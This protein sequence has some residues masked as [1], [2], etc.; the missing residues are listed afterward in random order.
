MEFEKKFKNKIQKKI[1]EQI[2]KDFQ[3]D[4]DYFNQVR[5]D[6]IEDTINEILR[7][8]KSIFSLYNKTVSDKSKQI[9]FDDKDITVDSLMELKR[10]IELTQNEKEYIEYENESDHFKNK[11]IEVII[12]VLVR[13]ILLEKIDIP[14]L[15]VVEQAIEELYKGNA[16]AKK[17]LHMKSLISG[18]LFEESEDKFSKM[19]S[20]RVEENFNFYIN[21]GGYALEVDTCIFPAEN[22]GNNFERSVSSILELFPF[23]RL[24]G[25]T[26]LQEDEYLVLFRA[27]K[28]GHHFIK[29]VDDGTFVEK[30]GG[31]APKKFVKWSESFENS[32]EAAFA[33]KKDHDIEYFD[34]YGSIIIPIETVK[35]FEETVIHTIQ[36]MQNTFEYHN[37]TF[38]LKKSDEG[39][40]YVCSMGKIVA[41]VLID[42]KDYDI[43]IKKEYK[44]YISNAKPTEI[45]IENNTQRTEK[46]DIEGGLHD[47]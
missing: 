42:D 29:Q 24:L 6:I 14:D 43:E 13:R 10:K 25:D 45:M 38:Q 21:C 12:E 47:R 26:K 37:H 33:V 3:G 4:W 2:E 7:E 9:Y 19:V 36:N 44:E 11:N 23:V 16:Y 27:S 15:T 8:I 1:T 40:I 30:E 22:D 46:N 34:K 28:N 18:K 31:H 32:Q 35:N 5:E 17:Y 20:D 39:I 41:Q